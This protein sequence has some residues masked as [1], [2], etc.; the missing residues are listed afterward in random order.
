[1]KKID[2]LKT[3]DYHSFSE[4]LFPIIGLIP[5]AYVFYSGFFDLPP[6]LNQLPVFFSLFIGLSIVHF[7]RRKFFV[8]PL[9]IGYIGLFFLPLTWLWR[10]LEFDDNVLMGI[11]PFN[12][13]MFYL[14]D[15]YRLLMGLDRMISPN[16]R[17]LYS[18]VLTFFMWLFD[19]NLQVS[20]AVFVLALAISV[21]LLVLE[22]REFAGPFTA[23]LAASMLFYFMLPFLGR[24]H[25]ENLGVALGALGLALLLRSARLGGLPA[26]LTGAFVLSL[27]L[28]ARAG[29]FTVLPAL[30]WWSWI[31]RKTYGWKASVLLVISISFGFIINTYLVKTFGAKNQVAFSN[32]GMSLYGL[33]AGY[34]GY[35]YILSVHPEVT[36]QTNAFPYALDLILKNPFML[37]YGML[38]SLKD[39]LTPSIMFYLMR[40]HGQQS[41]ISWMLYLMTLVGVYRLFKERRSSIQGSLVIFL[42]VG[43]LLSVA[44]IPTND[45]GPRALM[46]TNSLNAL[47]AGLAFSSTAGVKKQEYSNIVLP[48]PEMYAVFLGLICALGP[49]VAFKYSPE[50]PP[51][52]SLNCPDGTDQ[53]SVFVNPGSYINIVRD[54]PIF[55]F[56]PEVRKDDIKRRLDDY[57]SR[58]EVPYDALTNF[59]DFEDLIK[60]KLKP[61]DTIL[62]GPNLVERN[63]GD[64]PDEFVFLITRTDQIGKIGEVNHFCAYLSTSD[65]L[66]GN[67]FYFDKSVVEHP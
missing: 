5:L 67:R 14:M 28:N 30:L 32:Y 44:V 21:F 2:V 23:G 25:T 63:I 46:A 4:F 7:W 37:L 65:R 59:P 55:G 54:G 47:V 36:Y 3:E 20:L 52:P 35:G 1:M 51:I 57:Y 39:Y 62:I 43:I 64:G 49:F 66:Q 42:F 19:G 15:A 8:L 40:F 9:L 17:P 29:A 11:F 26:L 6:Y 56:V 31:N 60:R 53:I 48:L 12:D 16:V 45:G 22:I 41:L 34:K 13:G 38:L 58:G 50:I 24:V 10:G 61:G 18:G 33:A 27:A